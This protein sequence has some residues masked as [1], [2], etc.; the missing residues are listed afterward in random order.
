MSMKNVDDKNDS[1]D[2]IPCPICNKFYVKNIIEEH[3][4]K[5][6]FLNTSEQNSPKQG[7]SEINSSKRS[8]SHL[9]NVSSQEKRTRISIS[10]SSSKVTVSLYTT[11]VM[12]S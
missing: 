10:A 7:R 12:L 11:L 2:S 8:S 9:N 6:L 4:N 1:P 5:C 3:V